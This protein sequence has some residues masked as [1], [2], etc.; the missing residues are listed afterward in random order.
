M[1]QAGDKLIMAQRMRR[2]SELRGRRPSVYERKRESSS[3][4]LY[5]SR[6]QRARKIFLAEESPL[7]VVCKELGIVELA[8][9]V[10]HIIPHRGNLEL[11]WDRDNWQPLCKTHHSQKTAR[12]G[13]GG[14]KATDRRFEDR[15]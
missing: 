5:G 4:R 9:E 14:Q 6:W 10:D 8:T 11:F 13:R 12:E 1:L 7:C 2:L 15:G 3:K